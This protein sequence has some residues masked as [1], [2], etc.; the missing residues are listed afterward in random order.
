MADSYPT[1]TVVNGAA[2]TPPTFQALLLAGGRSTRMGPGADKAFLTDGDGTPLYLR[3]RALLQSL[4]PSRILLSARPGVNY[5][6]PAEDILLD[7]APDNG[8]LAA[9]EALS[10]TCLPGDVLPPTLVLAVDLPLMS[11]ELLRLLIPRESANAP[12]Q[13][14]TG[15]VF[16]LDGRLEPLAALYIPA[17]LYLAQARYLEG[18]R[19]VHCVLEEAIAKG[20]MHSEEVPDALRPCF[21]NLTTPEDAAAWTALS[22]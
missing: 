5:T 15:K 4:R 8:P 7:A 11:A 14:V 22:P 12:T 21:H 3:Q 13:P 17:V 2:A 16:T 20:L 10:R 18:T 1:F 6:W 9:I 19:A